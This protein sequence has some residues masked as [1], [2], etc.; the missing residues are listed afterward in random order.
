MGAGLGTTS[1]VLVVMAASRE[2]SAR[3]VRGKGRAPF[4]W[5]VSPNERSSVR[6]RP[7]GYVTI[8]PSTSF[9]GLHADESGAC[10]SGF[11]LRE[12]ALAALVGSFPRKRFRALPGR[13][14]TA[15]PLECA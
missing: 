5:S 1:A 12:R 7:V 15:H 13:R 2:L 9:A 8:A 6:E 14:R 4:G 10:W 11:Q 3:R